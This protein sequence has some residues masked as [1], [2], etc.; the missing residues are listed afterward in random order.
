MDIISWM[1]LLL[2]NQ[3]IKYKNDIVIIPMFLTL[4]ISFAVKVLHGVFF[5]CK[6]PIAFI[7]EF[8]KNQSSSSV[9]VYP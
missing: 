7:I 1:L 3:N 9:K 5:F 4:N 8:P 2:K 6:Y